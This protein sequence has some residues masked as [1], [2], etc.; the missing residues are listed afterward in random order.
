VA[1]DLLLYNIFPGSQTGDAVR[2]G[3]L[4]QTTRMILFEFFIPFPRF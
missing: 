4:V 1:I 3:I 2:L